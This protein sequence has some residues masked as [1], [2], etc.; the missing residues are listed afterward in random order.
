MHAV[1]PLV[2][3]PSPFEVEIAIAELKEYKCKSLVNGLIPAELFQAV[4]ESFTS[5]IHKLLNSI[6]SK[7]E[8]PHHWK[9]SINV[10]I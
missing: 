5:E 10:Q 3:D 7:E 1:E 6:W 8:L 9:E 2:S 4:G